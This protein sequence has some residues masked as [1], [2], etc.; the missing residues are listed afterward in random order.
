MK[1]QGT[2]FNPTFFYI[3][4]YYFSTFGRKQ[5]LKRPK[6]SHG[7]CN[8]LKISFFYIRPIITLIWVFL[9][10][11][12]KEHLFFWLFRFSELYFYTWNKFL[13]DFS[14]SLFDVWAG[15]AFAQ[16]KIQR[17][18]FIESLSYKPQIDFFNRFPV[19]KKLYFVYRRSLAC[20]S[21]IWNLSQHH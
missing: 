15:L 3:L 18:W 20:R 6:F 21:K 19:K 7:T 11:F 9:F 12:S 16:Y 13:R 14:I 17:G 8:S 4:K 10:F 5:I 2:V 1:L